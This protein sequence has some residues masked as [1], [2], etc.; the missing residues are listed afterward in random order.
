MS[1]ELSF[2]NYTAT[3]QSCL[4]NASREAE[5]LHHAQVQPEHLLLSLLSPES[6]T[7]WNLLAGTV[8]NP[9]VLQEGL[10]IVL[11]D[12]TP[13]TE[14]APPEYG[15]RMKRTLSEAEDEARRAGQ[16]QVDTGHMLLGLLDEG[17]AAGQMLRRSGFDAS[18]LRHWLRQPQAA[19]LPVAAPTVS[20]PVIVKP[21]PAIPKTRDERLERLE[22]QPLK[23][24]L[25][26]LISWPAIVVMLGLLVGSAVVMGADDF[27]LARAA[28]VVFIVDGWIIS[29]CAHEFAHAFTADLGGD[30]SV[31]GNGYLSF[32]PLKYTHPVLSILLPLLFMMMGG[33]GLPGGAVY[34]Q[35]Q[36]LRGPKWESAV[37]F[38]GP[39]ASALVT[40]LFALPFALN[41]FNSNI[42]VLLSPMLWRAMSA[43]VLLNCAA[44]ILNL[45][46][47]PPLDGF[48]IIAPIL[49]PSLRAM[50]A[51][52]SM[53]G[54]ILV[55]LA[56][57]TSP[58][59]SNFFWNTVDSMLKTL[60]VNP[61]LASL[62]LYQ[63]MFW[64]S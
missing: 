25:P 7:A 5:S 38:A 45:I 18:R 40:A 21:A 31:R 44:V 4:I 22:S 33:I 15:F 43:V 35:T 57:S 29:L 17:G 64:R 23:Q 49:S 13:A 8:R 48:G 14:A 46:P 6:G 37:S 12:A 51:S 47:I 54:L 30:R 39:A 20:R 10:R 61:Q 63:F 58:T 11:A 60:S 55:F 9:A 36:R 2:T 28:L 3:A 1:A 41:I 42:P 27:N 53:F 50:I 32:N 52:F 62:G 24:A 59:F 56:L 34:V 16:E 19:A 26:H